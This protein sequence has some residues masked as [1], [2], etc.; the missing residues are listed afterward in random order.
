MSSTP[1]TPAAFTAPVTAPGCECT[2]FQSCA[3]KRRAQQNAM[4]DTAAYQR[5]MGYIANDVDLQ[6]RRYRIE[7]RKLENEKRKLENEKR[8][9]ENEEM[10]LEIEK[11]ELENE[12]MRLEIEKLELKKKLQEL[13]KDDS[14]L[15]DTR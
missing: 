9:L 5:R 6:E 7:K 8:K 4:I 2:K 13:A 1:A 3:D 11:L 14:P 15:S 10:R 12:K